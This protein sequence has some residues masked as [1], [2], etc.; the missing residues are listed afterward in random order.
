MNTNAQL[1]SIFTSHLG[2]LHEKWGWLLA[3]G[4]AFILLGT[5]G[6]GMTFALTMVS[7]LFFGFLMLFGGVFQLVQALGCRGW[8]SIVLHVLVAI[9]YLI[10]GVIIVS[11]PLL[12]SEIITMMI[13]AIFMAMGIMRVTMAIQLKEVKG[14]WISLISGLLALIFGGMIMTAWP[15]SG[16][17][18]IGLLI[19]IDMIFHGW[20]YVALALVAKDANNQND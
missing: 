5:I 12:A 10:G 16:T 4:I 17:W 1:D 2:E 7:M 19:A 20:G 6:L 8:K 14:W 3:L 18:I 13:A 11:N 15:M 9:A